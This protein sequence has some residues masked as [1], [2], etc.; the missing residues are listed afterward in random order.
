MATILFYGL[1]FYALCGIV[2][3]IAFVTV[4]VARVLPHASV[5][6]PA[7]ILWLPGAAI[8]WPYVLLRWR[9]ARAA[10]TKNSAQ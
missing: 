10:A 2:T 1:A 3:G 7:R 8:L 5:T 4:G 6:A 9:Q